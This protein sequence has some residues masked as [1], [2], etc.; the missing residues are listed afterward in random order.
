MAYVEAILFVVS[1][2]LLFNE[3]FRG[4]YI[5]VA[6]AALI[7]MGSSY[8]L[9]EEFTKRLIKAELD[10]SRPSA[11]SPTPV[12]IPSPVS[13]APPSVQKVNVPSGSVKR[14][15]KFNDRDLC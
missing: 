15:I 5:V 9:F 8:M 10:A 4:N 1:S 12:V 13:P 11:V 3:R 2:G 7:A 14:C 6:A